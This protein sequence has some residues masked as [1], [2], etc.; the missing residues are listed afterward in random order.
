MTA[1]APTRR[2]IAAKTL[3][4]IQAV[5]LHS[6]AVDDLHARLCRVEAWQAEELAGHAA[7]EALTG[8][9]RLK[10]VIGL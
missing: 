3:Q 5:N 1:K 7:D 6:H 8:W 2:Q 9:Q 10:R 4:T